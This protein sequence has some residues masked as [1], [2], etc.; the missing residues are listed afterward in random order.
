MM[1]YGSAT[2]RPRTVLFGSPLPPTGTLTPYR[3]LVVAE[4]PVVEPVSLAEAKAQARIDADAEDALIQSY[5]TMARE[6][7]EGTLDISLITQTLEARYDLFPVW[8][9]ILPKPP[10]AAGTV[11]ITYRD[12]NDTV[13]TLSS[14]SSHFQVDHRVMPGRVYPN[15]NAVWPLPRGDEN[16]I[17]IRWQAGYGPTGF[18]VPATARGA[19]LLLVSHW[20]EMRQPVVTG[21]SQVLPIPKT[22]DTLIAATDWGVY[23]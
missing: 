20:F 3:S 22:V 11:T 10:M 8:E 7:L 13:Q 1:I 19:I 23:R 21:Y 17:T 14:A 18:D 12:G 15:Y 5:I 2:V 6:W 9:I 16:S 4:K